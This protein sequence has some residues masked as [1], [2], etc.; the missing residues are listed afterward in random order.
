MS[1]RTHNLLRIGAI[2]LFGA[3]PGLGCSGAVANASDASTTSTQAL[4]SVERSA[5]AA[6]PTGTAR[7]HASAYFLRLQAG[8]DPNMAARLVGA[9]TILP[10]VGQCSAVEVLGDSGLPLASLGPVDSVDVGTVTVEAAET[11][12]ILAPRAFPDVVDSVSGVVYTTR[13]PIA[14]RL[15][16]KGVYTFK[17]AGSLAVPPLAL[18][19][20]APG[21][22]EELTVGGVPLGSEATLLPRSDSTINWRPEP[23][24]DLVYVELASTEDGPLERVRCTFANEGQATIS[25]SALPKAASQSVSVHVVHREVFTGV[26]VDSGEIRFDLATNGALRFEPTRP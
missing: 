8:A 25:G 10:P 20:H 1:V 5:T 6:D 22:I 15:P 7:A 17:V 16:E 9:A 13:D 3:L 26:G 14:N 19:G 11:R 12:A 2:A 24:T 18:E 23:G 21:P 4:L